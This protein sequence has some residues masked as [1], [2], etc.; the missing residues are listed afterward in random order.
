MSNDVDRSMHIFNFSLL[1]LA[2]IV[3][4]AML[5]DTHPLEEYVS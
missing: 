2:V 1:A 3:I 5:V 4:G